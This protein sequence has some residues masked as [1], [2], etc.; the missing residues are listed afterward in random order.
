MGGRPGKRQLQSCRWKS[1]QTGEETGKFGFPLVLVI[2]DTGRFE[3]ESP[4][5]NLICKLE[6]RREEMAGFLNLIVIWMK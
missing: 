1:R 6:L 2:T 3:E 5:G 4:L